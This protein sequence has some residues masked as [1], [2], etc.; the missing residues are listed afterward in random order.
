VAVSCRS[1]CFCALSPRTHPY[2]RLEVNLV[3][4]FG[5]VRAEGLSPL[6]CSHSWLRLEAGSIPVPVSEFGVSRSI[7][8]D[9]IG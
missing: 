2:W 1:R 6:H 4:V 8:Y 7:S 3:P 5:W 9:T